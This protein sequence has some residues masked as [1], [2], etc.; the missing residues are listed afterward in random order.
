MP[1]T[2]PYVTSYSVLGRNPVGIEGGHALAERA[3]WKRMAELQYDQTALLAVMP[4]LTDIIDQRK[5]E[6]PAR[7]RTGVNSDPQAEVT[8]A[9]EHDPFAD[10]PE[11]LHNSTTTLKATIQRGIAAQK[12]KH[13]HLP[14]GLLGDDAVGAVAEMVRGVDSNLWSGEYNNPSSPVS[15]RSAAG[16]GVN[17]AGTAYLALAGPKWNTDITDANLRMVQQDAA[18]AAFDLDAFMS[19]GHALQLRGGSC[20]DCFLDWI[21]KGRMNGQLSTRGVVQ[22]APQQFNDEHIIEAIVTDLGKTNLH[23]V[24]RG[25]PARAVFFITLDPDCIGW[26]PVSGLGL[27]VIRIARKGDYDQF[28]IR[29]EYTFA[30]YSPNSVAVLVET[31]A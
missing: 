11:W 22:Y 9:D 1:I 8:D 6:W 3:I 10:E 14:R 2:D 7:T 21:N 12:F 23:L 25:M 18:G 19:L 29:F 30:L 17:A 15:I 26:A 31:A 24:Q 5:Y 4:K 27:Q 13:T 20:A 28:M 16:L